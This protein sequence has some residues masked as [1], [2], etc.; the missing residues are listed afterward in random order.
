VSCSCQVNPGYEDYCGWV[1]GLCS[2]TC[3]DVETDFTAAELGIDP[4][5]EADYD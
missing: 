2:C 5:E 3:H 4:E 1:E